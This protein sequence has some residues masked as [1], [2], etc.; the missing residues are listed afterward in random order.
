MKRICF[1]IVSVIVAFGILPAQAQEDG[2]VQFTINVPNPDAVNCQM[3]S[4]PYKLE[5]GA[6]LIDVPQYTNFYIE[7]V[8]PWKLTGVSNKAGTAVSGFYGDSWY[9]TVFESLQDEVFTLSLVNIDEFR[10]ASF[11]IN[12]DEPTLVNAVLGGYYTRLNLEAGENIIKYDPA[13]ETYLSIEPTNYMVPLYSVKMN[14][15][16]VAVQEY[17]SSYYVV[18]EE[19]CVIDIVAALPDE[20]HTVEFSYSEGAEGSIGISVNNQPMTDWDGKSITVKLGDKLTIEGNSRDYIFDEVMVNDKAVN[21]QSSSY[22]FAVM[23][24]SKVYINA[25]PYGN[26]KA[27]LIIPNPDLITFYNGYGGDVI[28]MQQGENVIELSE[29]DATISWAVDNMAILNRI[30][31]NGEDIPT[32]YSSYYLHDGD[33]LEFDITEKVFDKKAIIWIDNVNGKACS[34]YIGFSSTTDYTARFDLVNGYNIAAFYDQMNPFSLSWYGYSEEIPNVNLTGKV[35]LNDELLSP[36]YEGSSSYG[37]DLADNDVLKLFMDTTPVDC[38]VSFEVAEGTDATVVK[39]IVTAVEN[40]A[41]GFACFAGTEV[42]VAGK[43]ISVS[44][45]GTAL[46]ATENEEGESVFTFVVDDTDTMVA[47]TVAGGSAVSEINAGND[48]DVFNLQ[49]VKVGK[50]SQLNDLV[51]GIYIVNGKKAVVR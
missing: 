20:D 27:T 23:N 49:G 24:D 30:I 1:W 38:K 47:V 32:Y 13:V 10:T 40:P 42:S 29:K 12:V 45:N 2:N 3:N 4:E 5:K 14:G 22:S 35:Y 16:E 51:P 25:H 44:V 41:E 33:V 46:T 28:P 18:L 9:L 48:A 39:D 15:A 36:T 34:N 8:S 11:T 21:F 37:F 31:V 26:I 17:S 43:N 19:N 50:Q 7:G 6:N